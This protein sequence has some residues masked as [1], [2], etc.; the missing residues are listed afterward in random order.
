MAAKKTLPKKGVDIRGRIHELHHL[1]EY[2]KGS[3]V[4]RTLVNRKTGT[5]T[6]FAFDRRQGLSEHTVPHDAVVCVID[7]EVEIVISGKPFRLRRGNMII[8]PAREPHA[9]KAVKN[10]RCF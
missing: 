9:L 8:M 2:E 1:V 3:I 5:V 10:S 4:S 6:L 7:G